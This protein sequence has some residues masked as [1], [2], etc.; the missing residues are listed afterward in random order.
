MVANRHDMAEAE[1]ES[2][3]LFFAP[4][5]SSRM[6]PRTDWIDYNGHLNMAYYHVMF[7]QAVDE[8]F[9]LCGLGEDYVKIRR[10]SFFVVESRVS[11]R[12]EVN[13]DDR[14]R[15]TM[16]LI[17]FDEKRLHYYMEMRHASEGWLAA[18]CENL[19]IHVD[20][21]TRRAAP[22]P[23]E[24]RANLAHLKRAHAGLPRPESLGC[25]IALPARQA[26]N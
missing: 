20:M 24:I 21:A 2:P 7:D 13:R 4:F 6:V 5:V 8:A 22:F 16:Q 15:I 10:S 3:A 9:G 23:P 26:V 19:S 11:Y 18:T 12:R 1:N 25:G 17:D 14:V